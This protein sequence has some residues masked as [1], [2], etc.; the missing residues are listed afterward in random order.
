MSIYPPS[1]CLPMTPPA[2]HPTYINSDEDGYYEK[3]GY[4]TSA[5]YSRCLRTEK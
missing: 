1:G 4:K 3:Q 5:Q 2:S